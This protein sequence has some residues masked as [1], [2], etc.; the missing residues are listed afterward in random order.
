MMTLSWKG[1]IGLLLLLSGLI[2]ILYVHL[3]I[4]LSSTLTMD[5]L[6]WIWMS[7]DPLGKG[8]LDL[9]KCGPPI[10][11]VMIWFN[12][13]GICKLMGLEL[14]N[15]ET[16]YQMP[17]RRLWSGIGWY[18]V[19]WK[20]KSKWNNFNCRFSRIP[21]VLLRMQK[22]KNHLSWRL[23][24]CWIG[25]N[26]CGLKRQ[27]QSG[28]FR[29]TETLTIFKLWFNREEL[30]TESLTSRMIKASLLTI[31]MR[32]RPFLVATLGKIMWAETISVLRI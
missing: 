26:W 28:F 18:L 32:L 31:L 27:E 30:E 16:N 7:K 25:R 20:M 17:E 19:E 23:R 10:L 13:H 29:G 6:F 1:W 2:C 22:E 4:C 8:L 3:E 21:S 9:N 24:I 11:L 14:L 15:W 12:S 5:Q